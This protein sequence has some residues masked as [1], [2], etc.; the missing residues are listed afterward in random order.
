MHII[1]PR[2]QLFFNFFVEKLTLR[3]YLVD[4]FPGFL[5]L[6]LGICILMKRL[7]EGLVIPTGLDIQQK[8]VVDSSLRLEIKLAIN[9]LQTT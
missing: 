2:P 1:S 8:R 7:M 5:L 9:P 3:E 6:F 4:S